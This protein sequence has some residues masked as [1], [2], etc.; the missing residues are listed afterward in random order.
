[1][2]RVSQ[3][4]TTITRLGLPLIIFRCC[5]AVKIWQKASCP[6]SDQ[7]LSCLWSAWTGILSL[8]ISSMLLV[9][10]RASYSRTP[11]CWFGID[12]ISSSYCAGETCHKSLYTVLSCLGQEIG[13]HVDLNLIKFSIIF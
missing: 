13:L 11:I 10:K 4:M 6:V 9:H 12:K 8:V 5:L 7:L 1:M 2:Y 3:G